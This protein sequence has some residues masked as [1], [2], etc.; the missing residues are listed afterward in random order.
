VHLK[1]NVRTIVKPLKEAAA[2]DTSKARQSAFADKCVRVHIARRAAPRHAVLRC[3]CVA[4]CACTTATWRAALA[5]Y[6]CVRRN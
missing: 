4:R 3:P 5:R 2:K 1:P 6:G